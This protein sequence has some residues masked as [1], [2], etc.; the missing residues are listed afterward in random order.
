MCAHAPTRMF[1]LLHLNPEL[2]DLTD[3]ECG[4]WFEFK[5]QIQEHGQ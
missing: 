2:E 3:S 4:F 1:T 5:S